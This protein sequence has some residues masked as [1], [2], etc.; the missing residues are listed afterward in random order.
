MHV[1]VVITDA[2]KTR[3]LL[4]LGI[5]YTGGEPETFEFGEDEH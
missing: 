1:R 2:E 4:S 3:C 5:G